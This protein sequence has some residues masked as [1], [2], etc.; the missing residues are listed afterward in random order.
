[1]N[2]INKVAFFVLSATAAFSII[3]GGTASVAEAQSLAV[4]CFTT[5]GSTAVGESVFWIAEP[6]GGT[7]AYSYFWSGTDGLS[8]S[9]P[10][11]SISYSVTGTKSAQVMVSSGSQSVTS[12]C[13]SI[14]IVERN[15]THSLDAFCMGVPRVA[16]VGELVHWAAS[17][18]GGS[19]SFTIQ[20]SG[21]D[22][23]SGVGTSVNRSYSTSGFKSAQITVS[24]G[25]E[26]V[27]RSCDNMAFIID[28]GRFDTGIDFI[29]SCA[30]HKSSVGLSETVIWTSQVSGGNGSFSYVWSGTDSLSGF[31][32]SLSRS[33]SSPGFKSAMLTVTSDSRTLTATCFPSVQV[34]QGTTITSS[35]FVT[36][37]VIPSAIRVG[38]ATTWYSTV[39]GG[40]GS[41]LY[42]WS[43]TD[44]LSGNSATVQKFYTVPGTKFAS[45]TVAS[46]GQSAS[47]NCGILSVAQVPLT[48]TAI[49][50]A[51]CFVDAASV[52]VGME[53][54]WNAIVSGGT[55]TYSYSWVGS[56]SLLGTSRIIT[57]SYDTLGRKFGAVTVSSGSE[58]VH[59]SCVNSVLV[60]RTDA[61]PLLPAPTAV[62]KKLE[63]SCRSRSE[64]AKI[65]ESVV[66]EAEARGGSN[67]YS[68][69]WSGTDELLGSKKSVTKSYKSAGA[70][71]AS[72]KITSGRDTIVLPC[73]NAVA[74]SALE[75]GAFALGALR[76]P[77]FVAALVVIVLLIAIVAILFRRTRA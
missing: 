57:R 39:S 67:V 74:V 28:D 19:G 47:A 5:A 25:G 35:L 11:V 4:R 48:A 50:Q 66:W 10:N 55:G 2:M 23:L 40:T 45:L 26:T 32:S 70:K 43:G 27:N 46:G 68:Y 34:G 18:F 38:E 54:S 9:G 51:S 3:F 59:R 20:W 13:G 63:G 77:L 16:R 72:V 53:V 24:S 22:S 37:A 1:M 30:P 75:Q 31:G 56:D 12:S 36:C 7:G 33:Y 62:A 73:E 14:T 76:G 15:V 42:F 44:V 29:I 69:A 60:D 71:I 64:F 41:Y 52:R 17:V 6:S 21:T 61:L 49:L 58:T 65:G 8:G